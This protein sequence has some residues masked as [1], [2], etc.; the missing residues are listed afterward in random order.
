M[1]AR[2]S[3]TWIKGVT[4]SHSRLRVSDDSR[5]KRKSVKH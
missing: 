4:C 2:S 1:T 3:A 5:F